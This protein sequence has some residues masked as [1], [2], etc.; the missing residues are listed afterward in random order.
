MLFWTKMTLVGP[1]LSSVFLVFFANTFPENKLTIS[2]YISIPLVFAVAIILLLISTSYNI[3]SVKIVGQYSEFVPGPL[4]TLLVV[5]LLF[6]LSYTTIVFMRKHKKVGK[7]EKGQIKSILL[8]ILGSVTGGLILNVVLP[9]RGFP[10]YATIGS[11]SV[12]FLV[13]GS[14]YAILKHKLLDI[15]LIVTEVV[16]YAAL[17]ILATEIFLSK[18]KTELL[19]R[20]MFMIL[21]LFGGRLLIRSM[22]TEVSRRKEIEALAN[23]RTIALKEVEERNKNLATLQKVSEIVLNENDMKVMAQR[24]LNEL[25]KELDH[26]IGALLS[27]VRDSNLVAY[28]ISSSPFTDKIHSLVGMDLEKYSSPIKKDFNLMHNAI[29]EHRAID[30]ESL[31]DFISPPVPK[32]VAFTIQK[33]VGS[34]HIEAIPLYASGEP[35]GV[36]MFVFT[37][38]KN[39][40]HSNNFEIAKSIADDMSLAIQRAQAFQ[41]LK[42]ANEYLAQMDK[43]KDEFI[44]MASHEL[45]TPLAAIEGYLSMIL[46]EGMGGKIDAKTREYL[47]RAY[48]SSKRLAEL[49]LDLLNVSRIE[50][51]RLKMK[52]S[53]CNLYE[54]AESVIHELQIKSDAKKIYLKLEGDKTKVPMTW[55]D[56]DRIREIFVNLAGNAIKFT[57]KGGITIMVEPGEGNTVRG[58]VTDTGRGIAKEDQKKLFQKFSQVKREIDEHQGTGLGLYI[59]KNFVELHKGRIWV[60]SEAGKGAKFL[61][62]LPILTEEPKE[63]D[64]AILERPINAPQIEAGVKDVPKIITDSTK[65]PV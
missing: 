10:E 30:S 40:I 12:V 18:T 28:A 23:A 45:N 39:E 64:G 52:F 24:I 32:A 1:A 9:I 42:E 27:V 33:L 15:R 59:S 38:S 46:D 20:V 50:Q 51:G 2:K 44:S 37:N 7:E 36:M 25:P 31:S 8:G 6:S 3:E 41:K 5:M 22:N 11:A 61:F 65:V 49:I 57:E 4:Y 54:L 35:F 55:C 53:Q 48:A 43:M 17:I 16:T 63:V 34:Q 21:A 29:V 19:F 26:C 60:E 14:G 13:I 62:E 56:P 47:S 58:S